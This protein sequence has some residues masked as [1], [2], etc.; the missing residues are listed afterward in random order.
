MFFDNITINIEKMISSGVL[1]E[2]HFVLDCV[3]KSKKDVLS[4]YLEKCGKIS[5]SAINQL[6]NNAYIEEIDLNE[7]ITFDKFIITEKGLKYF[8]KEKVNH[9]ELFD[10]FKGLFPKKTPQ[11]RRLHLDPDASRKKYKAIVDSIETHN[12]IIKCLK[13]EIN[14]R[15]KTAN[16][17]F[18]NSM[19]VWLNQKNYKVYLD[20]ALEFKDN[21][22]QDEGYDIV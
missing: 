8:D 12:T 7:K 11:G 22:G 13:L 2:S 19:P 18:M 3:L 1:I 5:T 21:I 9:D 14:D 4:K 16:L 6:M 15:T 10:E 17:D 20:E